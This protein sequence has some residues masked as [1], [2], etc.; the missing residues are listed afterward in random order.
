M[1][2]SHY[3]HSAALGIEIRGEGS[4]GGL[5]AMTYSGWRDQRE[6]RWT[7]CSEQLDMGSKEEERI[8]DVLRGQTRSPAEWLRHSEKWDPE[9]L[10]VCGEGRGWH[11]A[12]VIGLAFNVHYGK[13]SRNS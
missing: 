10:L 4:D 7:R 13:S 12:N 8:W 3:C 5:E 1:V 9:G 11:R 2:G 6:T